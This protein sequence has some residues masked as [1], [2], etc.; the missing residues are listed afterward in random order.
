MTLV[1]IFMVC[2]P[3]TGVVIVDNVWLYDAAIH[4]THVLNTGDIVQITGYKGDTT[5]VRYHDAVG[6][7]LKSVLIDLKDGVSEAKLLVF[8]RGYYDSEE[9]I[10]SASLFNVFVDHYAPSP[11][12]PEALYYYG[13]SLE[14]IAQHA[15]DVDTIKNIHCNE[16]SKQ[17]YYTGD[18]YEKILKKF[19]DSIFA[20]K[21]AYRLITIFRTKHFPW[22]DSLQVIREELSMWQEYIVMYKNSEEY[23]LA[24]LEIGY[25]ERVLF[26]ITKNEQYKKDAQA[27][28]EE[29]VSDY[30]NTIYAAQAE[31]HLDEL[32]KGERIYYY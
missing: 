29:I 13:L 9:Y 15:A 12:L 3:H 18:A 25:V 20:S 19:S 21:A 27:V 30:P 2:F 5:Q 1:L 32:D 22:N 14:E 26:E 4:K 11:Y 31:V 24:L 16:K 8:A 17:W 28:F 10:K 23:V 6:T 7:L